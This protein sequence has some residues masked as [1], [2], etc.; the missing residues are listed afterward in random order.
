VHI[1]YL[2]GMRPDFASVTAH[3]SGTAVRDPS[4]KLSAR[5]ISWPDCHLW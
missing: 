5:V 2:T 1:W 3:D 4:A